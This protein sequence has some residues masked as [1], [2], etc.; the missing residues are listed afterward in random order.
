MDVELGG[1]TLNQALDELSGPHREVIVLRFY[2][3]LKIHEI[4]RRLGVSRGT[5][6]SR[7]HYAIGKLQERLPP[8]MN[9][10]GASGTETTRLT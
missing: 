8:E 2:E 7:L 9:L 4:A 10:F 3:D 6:K 5:V 1:S